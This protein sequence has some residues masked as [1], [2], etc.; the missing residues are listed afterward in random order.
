MKDRLARRPPDPSLC[1]HIER[2]VVEGVPLASHQA[3]VLEV[4]L[5]AELGRMLAAQGVP[6]ALARGGARRGIDGGEIQ[7]GHATPPAAAAVQ[8][9]RAV[10]GG[11][12]Q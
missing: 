11:L 7:M 12:C 5:Q 1:L 10:Y 3:A 2:V 4:A 9:A 8:L 6:P